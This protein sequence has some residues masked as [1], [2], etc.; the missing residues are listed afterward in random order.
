M[1][2]A[3]PSFECEAYMAGQYYDYIEEH[4]LER[5][6]LSCYIAP[7]GARCADGTIPY[8]GVIAC[9][10]EHL[11]MT[12][13]MYNAELVPVAVWECHDVG[14]NVLLQQGKAIDVYRDSIER[15]YE[16]I[17]KYGD[18]VYIEWVEEETWND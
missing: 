15:C 12:C 2:I 18:Y 6:R 14:G 10:A 5:V 4:N 1:T 8:E 3:P 11:G 16:L 13:I 17:G 7:E 9:N